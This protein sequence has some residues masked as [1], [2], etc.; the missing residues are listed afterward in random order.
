MVT[1]GGPGPRHPGGGL[2]GHWGHLGRYI[3]SLYLIRYTCGIRVNRSN[4]STT[5]GAD[6][7]TGDGYAHTRTSTVRQT[8]TTDKS[9]YA[10]VAG[11]LQEAYMISRSILRRKAP[12]PPHNDRESRSNQ[13]HTAYAA[14]TPPQHEHA[15]GLKPRSSYAY[16]RTEIERP[17]RCPGP[18]PP[19]S[20]P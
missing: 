3:R 6:R 15:R 10:P 16:Q 9:T 5:Q 11:G 18:I 14:W 7:R 17:L 12:T 19:T 20:L 8:P 2:R 4:E 1:G 13:I